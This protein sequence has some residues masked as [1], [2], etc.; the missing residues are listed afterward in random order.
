MAN[1]TEGR[2]TA[3]GLKLIHYPMSLGTMREFSMP[4]T[5]SESNTIYIVKPR[6]MDSPPAWTT[7]VPP[8]RIS[9][10][11]SAYYESP[12][13]HATNFAAAKQLVAKHGFTNTTDRRD[14]SCVYFR[15]DGEVF[16]Q[17]GQERPWRVQFSPSSWAKQY[18]EMDESQ[19]QNA[20]ALVSEVTQQHADGA[21]LT[22]FLASR[23]PLLQEVSQASVMCAVSN[24]TYPNAVP[25]AVIG[26]IAKHS[27]ALEANAKRTCIDLALIGS[28]LIDRDDFHERIEE[29]TELLDTKELMDVE[30]ALRPALESVA[31]EPFGTYI[32]SA[33]EQELNKRPEWDVALLI[34]D[35]ADLSRLDEES[36]KEAMVDVASKALGYAKHFDAPVL[37]AVKHGDDL[38]WTT[39]EPNAKQP[40]LAPFPLAERHRAAILSVPEQVL[41]GSWTA[42]D[43]H[44]ARLPFSGCSLKQSAFYAQA[45][46]DGNREYF[47]RMC[48]ERMLKFDRENPPKD[49][50]P[51][52]AEAIDAL[53]PKDNELGRRLLAISESNT[54]SRQS[55]R[56]YR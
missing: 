13:G 7:P 22:E 49:I 56:R 34:D 23:D 55:G 44:N 54:H 43:T 33:V 47:Q 38:W 48:H 5:T 10:I 16:S 4:E 11:N 2:L 24:H 3:V 25:A 40:S 17:T 9:D 26:A 52:I 32:E 12:I 1:G 21:S 30:H 18:Q 36:R 39:A 6:V 37:V 27:Q 28:A 20:L 31:V 19:V 45:G 51:A 53:N 35:P 42:Q 46:R 29:V 14:Q 41:V 8:N 15:L 50:H